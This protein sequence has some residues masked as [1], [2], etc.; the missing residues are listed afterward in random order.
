[1][2]AECFVVRKG[3]NVEL[4]GRNFIDTKERKVEKTIIL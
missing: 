4:M 1:M 3:Q 2:A